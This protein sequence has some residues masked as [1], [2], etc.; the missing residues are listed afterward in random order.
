MP[1]HKSL[2]IIVVVFYGGHNPSPFLDR[3]K[4]GHNIAIDLA[5]RI[6]ATFAA[7]GL[8][9]NTLPLLRS[10]DLLGRRLSRTNKVIR[11][12]F[13]LLQDAQGVVD[14]GVRSAAFREIPAAKTPFPMK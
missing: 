10:N 2:N 1:L 9:R 8:M 5:A 13:K 14:G 11:S 3:L 7:P 12:D 6:N 4:E